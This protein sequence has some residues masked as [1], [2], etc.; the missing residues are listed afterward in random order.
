[1]KRIYCPWYPT[2]WSQNTIL[3]MILRITP[4]VDQISIELRVISLPQL[5]Y[6]LFFFLVLLSWADISGS[7]HLSVRPGAVWINELF[8]CV[9]HL[10]RINLIWFDLIWFDFILRSDSETAW[11]HPTAKLMVPFESLKASSERIDYIPWFDSF[12]LTLYPCYL[13]DTMFNIVVI[14]QE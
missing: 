11:D 10:W 14:G 8:Y 4:D 13:R 7:Y 12:K 1:M 5:S 3:C 9:L 2:G 6:L